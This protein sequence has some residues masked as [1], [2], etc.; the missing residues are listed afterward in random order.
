MTAAA[1]RTDAVAGPGVMSTAEPRLARTVAGPSVASTAPP[2][3]AAVAE[4]VP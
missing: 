3:W 4:P 2:P 1:P